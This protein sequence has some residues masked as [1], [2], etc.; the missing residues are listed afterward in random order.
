MVPSPSLL[1]RAAAAPLWGHV[2]VLLVVLVVFGWFV[3]PGHAFTSDEGAA[4]L[5]AEQLEATGSWY[6]AYPLRELGLG[7]EAR[8]FPLGES[9]DKGNTIYA[10]HPLY[11]EILR[12]ANDAG[13]V[14]LV[15]LSVAGA[16]LAAA[17]AALLA[18]EVRPSLDRA[19][20]WV[21]GVASPLL[22]D[23]Y[24]VL[25]HTLAA[26]G[27]VWAVVAAVR[28]LQT[29]G[30]A[31]VA[32]LVLLGVLVAVTAALRSEGAFLG[33][34]LMAAALGVW[35]T[36]RE[37]RR[38]PAGVALVALV[39]TCITWFAEREWKRALLGAPTASATLEASTS[40]VTGRFEGLTTTWFQGDY[41]QRRSISVLL[42]L[43]CIALAFGALRFRLHAKQERL[44]T[45]ALVFA[46]VAYVIVFLIGSP[47]AVPGLAI[48]FPIGWVGLW[49]CAR[50]DVVSTGGRL[51]GCVAAVA[52]AGVLLTQYAQGGG[53]EWGGRYFLFCVPIATPV[54][55]AAIVR[56]A[57]RRRAS[58]QLRMA[59]LA[60][61]TVTAV[62]LGLIGLLTVRDAHEAVG[63]VRAAIASAGPVAGVAAD[64]D[65]PVVVGVNP[66][67]P[68]IVHQD[69]WSYEWVVPEEEDLGAALDR[70]ATGGIE[71]VVFVTSSLAGSAEHLDGWEVVF[72]SDVPAPQAVVVLERE[73]TGSSRN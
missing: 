54:L 59:A 70:L 13:P 34:A 32:W 30:R 33:P 65:H 66:L 2:V 35:W 14:G 41:D 6:Y 11:V 55:L 45:G 7:D 42:G 56:T 62:V 69:F 51:C 12:A 29:R 67:L 57:E 24:L 61:A 38:G 18:R 26:A 3:R 49:L 43:A 72:T 17:G 22:F 10:R 25:A 31:R 64:L 27:A 19:T 46:A 36:K 37:D 71:R 1:A 47:G 9:G 4:I 60:A 68:Q 73:S 21:V 16:V 58:R 63:Q 52:A 28:A 48:A 53:L 23:S 5:Q 40:W 44:V 20:L 39:A 15:G 8:P 50:Q